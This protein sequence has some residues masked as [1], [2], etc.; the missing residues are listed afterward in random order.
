M[1]ISE[2]TIFSSLKT[3]YESGNDIIGVF[4]NLVLLE[5]STTKISVQEIKNKL[6]TNYRF[7]VPSDV[8]KTILKRL[9]QKN[10]IFFDNIN[11]Q[12]IYILDKGDIEKNKIIA[13]FKNIDRENSALIKSIQNYIKEKNGGHI[14]EDSAI[15]KELSLFIEN[16]TQDAINLMEKSGDVVR[17]KDKIVQSFIASFFQFS[18]KTDPIN[19]ERLKSA[20]YGKIVSMS[21]LRKNFEKNAKFDNLSIYL[22]T[23]IFFSL[24]GIHEDCYNIPAQEL[25]EVIKKLSINLKIFSFT[26]D[27]I[28]SKLRG[29]L[30]NYDYYTKSINVDSIYNVLKRKNYSKSDVIKIIENVENYIE[31]KGIII[32]YSFDIEDLIKKDIYEDAIQKYKLGKSVYS[33]K[34]DI[35]IVAAIRKLRN[36]HTTS[37]LEK[38]KAI[39][40]TADFNLSLYNFNEFNHKDLGTIPEVIV[41]NDLSAILWL[42]CVDKYD[43]NSYVHSVIAGHVRNQMISS[44]LWEK[45]INEMKNQV[46]KGVI[47]EDDI[48]MLIN[49]NETEKILRESGEDGIKIII[50]DKKIKE[51]RDEQKLKDDSL[52]ARESS[53]KEAL[54]QIQTK[55]QEIKDNNNIIQDQTGRIQ[56]ILL[57]IEV[58]CR[59]KVNNNINYFLWLM[60]CSVEIVIILLYLLNIPTYL[61]I[62]FSIL[63]FGILIELRF[64][65]Q[66]IPEVIKKYIPP[67]FDFIKMRN[68]FESKSIEKLIIKNK[69]K[70]GIE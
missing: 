47:T 2:I 59:K 70:L 34:H 11:L 63:N 28:V 44:G 18:E 8:I 6:L 66:F 26:K 54:I 40:L 15:E 65:I 53:L 41:R 55:D 42:K 21:L 17:Y 46:E 51:L 36:G 56:N 1:A 22:D 39:F 25:V 43:G 27:E 13:N 49:Y 3:F 37:L 68:N 23:N 16:D 29:Y 62:F 14:I 30:K 38:S 60:W 32:D 69:K 4:G 48:T 67:C 7:D 12:S 52:V 57:N 5:T 64:K 58:A 10:L 31:E 33:I 45:F 24:I 20:L 61:L 9:K 50:S 35:A 19:F